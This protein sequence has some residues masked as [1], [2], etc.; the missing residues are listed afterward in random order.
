MFCAYLQGWLEQLR[1]DR[2][3]IVQAAA[4]AQK[5]ADFILGNGPDDPLVTAPKKIT[6]PSRL[7]EVCMKTFHPK[8][9]KGWEGEVKL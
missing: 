3:M 6:P 1:N 9:F 4:Q 5:A 7:A 2:T 8:E